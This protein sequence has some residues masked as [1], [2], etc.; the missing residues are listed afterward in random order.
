[1]DR[2]SLRRYRRPWHPQWLSQPASPASQRGPARP[3][4]RSWLKPVLRLVSCDLGPSTRIGWPKPRLRDGRDHGTLDVP[5]P[6]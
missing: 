6:S 4:A 1:M 5:L 3:S 2:P